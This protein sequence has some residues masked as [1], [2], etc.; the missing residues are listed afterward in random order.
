MALWNWKSHL[1]FK[2]KIASVLY[3]FRADVPSF[4]LKNNTTESTF[5]I[6]LIN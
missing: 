4:Y 3:N 6:I 5:K 2:G 1:A